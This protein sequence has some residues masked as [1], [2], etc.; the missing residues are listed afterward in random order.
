[1]KINLRWSLLRS[2]KAL[3]NISFERLSEISGVSTNTLKR[4]YLFDDGEGEGVEIGGAFRVCTALGVTMDEF[5]SI[6]KRPDVANTE[7]HASGE[8][9][10]ALQALLA[11]KDS[12]I[13]SMN[14][15]FASMNDTI[16]AQQATIAAKDAT[17]EALT[18]RLD[19]R[20]TLIEQQREEKHKLFVMI[21][22]ILKLDGDG[23]EMSK[24]C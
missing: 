24:M 21:N 1:M 18:S 16:A 5:T 9:V 17:I 8:A 11:A 10:E 7:T 19:Y 3:Q 22:K 15:T 12:T 14:D 6:T 13:A 23:N 2:A 20:N 4:W